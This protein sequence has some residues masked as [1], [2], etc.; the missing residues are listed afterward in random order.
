M[1]WFDLDNTP[2]VPLF[3]FILKRLKEKNINY[4]VTA[5]NFAQTRELL[6]FYKIE[7]HL[8]GAHAGKNKLLKSINL[9]SR[10]FKLKKLI[11]N[12]KI[13]LAI[14][15]GSRTQLVTAKLSNINS[16][17]MI[18][19][20]FTESKIFNYL[21]KYVLVPKFI[22][23][24]RLKEAGFDLKKIIRY[25]GFKEELYLNNFIPDFNF[26][27]SIGVSEDEIL[28]V[29]RPPSMVSN[30][31]NKK[32]E[33]LLIHSLNHLKKNEKT[34]I[35]IVNRTKVEKKFLEKKVEFTENVKFLD[36]AVDGLQLVYAAD[37]TI[38]GGG[39][40]NRESALV[41]TDTYSIFCGKH[42]Y[43]DEY[44]EQLG[45]LKFINKIEDVSKIEPRKNFK[46][47]I[48]IHNKDLVDEIID[49]F[50][51]ISNH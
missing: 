15:H 17:V 32:S 4:F 10:T 35:L 25:N 45:R 8:V 44:L 50:F 21:A 18:D 43:L 38:S 9:F 14:S 51:K 37:M 22:P 7:Y 5:R 42:P 20:E 36:K 29:V 40:M 19:Y 11:K 27:K 1:F 31:H 3:R 2:H 47:E 16:I 34:K 6:D 12:K 30:Y 28:I 41:G 39:T 46:K 26:R 13:N 24:S 33:E 48:L 23:D 49:L